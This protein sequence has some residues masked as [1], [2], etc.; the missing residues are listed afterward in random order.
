M[1][2]AAVGTG[3]LARLSS[4][5]LRARKG[6]GG[7]ALFPLG[8]ADSIDHGRRH[9]SMRAQAVGSLLMLL[10]CVIASAKQEVDKTTPREK[11]SPAE[12]NHAKNMRFFFSIGEGFEGTASDWTE[13][14][15]WLIGVCGIFFYMANPN[16]RRNLHADY[17]DDVTPAAQQ[18]PQHGADG[19]ELFASPSSDGNGRA[20]TE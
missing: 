14:F 17:D 13:Y 12:I 6:A 16:A 9:V 7:T 20:K 11:L 4:R 18:Q 8:R 15:V 19:D 5:A 1:A 3:A 10:C 2:R